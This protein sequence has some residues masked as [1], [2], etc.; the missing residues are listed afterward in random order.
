MVPESELFSMAQMVSV[1]SLRLSIES[2]SAVFSV[3]IMFSMF[4]F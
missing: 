4:L 3:S 2:I 1:I